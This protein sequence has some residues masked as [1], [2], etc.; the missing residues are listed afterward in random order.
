GRSGDRQMRRLHCTK[1]G[2]WAAIA[3]LL[4]GFVG[5]YGC[6][7][8]TSED[9]TGPAASRNADTSAPSTPRGLIMSVGS[10]SQLDLSWSASTDNVAVAGSSVLR[11]DVSRSS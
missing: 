2:G 8:S 1:L 6:G 5:L 7:A 4:P 3:A 9:A 10:D 11:D